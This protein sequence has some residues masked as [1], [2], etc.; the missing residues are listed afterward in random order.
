VESGRIDRYWAGFFGLTPEEFLQPGV[1]IVPHLGLGDYH[2]AWLFCHGETGVISVPAGEVTAVARAAGLTP[3]ALVTPETAEMLFGSAIER[4]VGPAYQGYA[5]PRDF[6][7]SPSPHVR[8]LTPDD[9][10]AFGQLQAACDPVEWMLSR[11]GPDDPEV[12]G[13]VRDGAI[14]AVCRPLIW[15]EWTAN[16]GVITHPVYRGRGYG[17]AVVSASMQHAFER[18]YLN[19]YQTLVAN[20]GAVG[21]ARALG[22]REYGRSLAVRFR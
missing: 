18:G 3:G 1:R 15:N 4:L 2:G 19:V 20:A 7:P 22:F 14:L 11:L 16:H 9:R 13:Y 10:D 12:F 5:E 6:R 21:I 17:K 8:A